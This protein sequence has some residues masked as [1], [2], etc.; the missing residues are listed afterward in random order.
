MPV[1]APSQ[2]PVGPQ[3]PSED[4]LLYAPSPSRFIVDKPYTRCWEQLA[5]TRSAVV[6]APLRVI[7]PSDSA[8]SPPPIVLA[9]VL[10][11]IQP[12]M[13]TLP[14]A[15]TAARKPTGHWAQ[16][17]VPAASR[18]STGAWSATIHS[19]LDLENRVSL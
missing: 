14:V 5:E 8:R 4:S 2:A 16:A 11:P 18:P 17:P 13:L 3:L 10:Y 19:E 1:S 9:L 7:L 15:P 6:L 12:R